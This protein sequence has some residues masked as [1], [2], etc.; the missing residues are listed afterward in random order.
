MLAMAIHVV[1]ADVRAD[2]SGIGDAD[3]AGDAG[4]SLVQAS[5]IVPGNHT[6]YL[7]PSVDTD[8]Y[9]AIG[10][11]AGE[12]ISLVLDVPS[13]L[14]YDLQLYDPTDVLVS[15]STN[16]AGLNES[17]VYSI[18]SDGIWKVRVHHVSGSGDGSY[19]LDII[20]MGGYDRLTL[21]VGSFGDD[22]ISQHLPGISISDGT[23]WSSPSGGGR[24]ASVNSSFL[25]NLYAQTYQENTRYQLSIAYVSVNDVNLSVLLGGVWV[26]VAALPGKASSW[27]HSFVLDSG[28]LQDSSSSLLGMNV[29]LRFEQTATVLSI[30]AVPVAYD[31]D[32]FGGSECY[33]GVMPVS[34]WTSDGMV[35]NGSSGATLRVTLP[36]ADG[37]FFLEFV[38]FGSWEGI[39]VQQHDGSNWVNVGSLRT[40]GSSAVLQLSSS[41]HDTLPSVPGVSLLIRLTS[42]SVNL[43]QVTLWTSLRNTDVGTNGDMDAGRAGISLPNNGLWS[44]AAVVDGR[45][46]RTTASSLAEFH[47]NGALSDSPYAVSI[48]YKTGSASVSVQQYLGPSAGYVSLGTLTGDGTWRTSTFYTSAAGMYDHAAGAP[49]NVLFRIN[50]PSGTVIVDNIAMCID[51][52][53]DGISDAMESIRVSMSGIGTYTYALNPFSADTDSDGLN[54]KEEMTSYGTNPTDPDTDNDGLLDGSEKYSYSWGIEGF[55]PI[56]NNGKLTFTISMPAISGPIESMNLLIGITHPD[57]SE[58][59]VEFGRIT[60]YKWLIIPVYTMKTVKDSGTGSGANYFASINLFTIASPYTASDFGTARTWY[61]YV[62]DTAAD[63]DTGRLDYVKLQVNGRTDPLNSDSDGDGISDGEEVNF[64]ADGWITNPRS[65]DSDGDGVSDYNEINGNTLCGHILDP[66]NPDTDDDGYN[67]NVDRYYGDAVIRLTV[68][69]YKSWE[70]INNGNT[71]NI[72]FVITYDGTSL[73]TRR[74]TAST[75]GMYYPGWIY[76]FDVPDTATSASMTLSAVADDAGWLGDD[77]KLDV[78]T[79]SPTEYSFT[80]SLSTSVTYYQTEGGRDWS[81]GDSDAYMRVSM[82]TRVAE[83]ARVIVVNGTGAD[84]DYGLET[85]STGSYRYSADDQLYMVN[86]NVSNQSTHFQQGANT[87]IV[88]RAIA[89]ACQMND[90]LANVSTLPSSNPFHGATFHSTQGGSGSSHVVAVIS[91]KVNGAVAETILYM[92]TQDSSDVRIGNNVTIAAEIVYLLHLPNDVV[93]SI[94][95]IIQNSGLGA[96]PN[97]LDPL[98]VIADIVDMVFNFLLYVYTTTM[99]YLQHLLDIGLQNLGSLVAASAAAV[100]AALDVIVDAFEAYVVWITEMM[101]SSL[102]AFFNPIIESIQNLVGSYL[103]NIIAIESVMIQE[104]QEYGYAMTDTIQLMADLILGELFRFLIDVAIGIDIMIISLLLMTGGAAFLL[105]ILVGILMGYIMNNVLSIAVNGSN[106]VVTCSN[107]A[108][109]FTFAVNGYTDPETNYTSQQEFTAFSTVFTLTAMILSCILICVDMAFIVGFALSIISLIL[110]YLA[111]EEDSFN[112]GVMGIACSISSVMITVADA[113]VKKR[114]DVTLI[115]A[116]SIIASGAA[117]YCSIQ[118]L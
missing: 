20:L 85:T 80:Y 44:S 22:D 57:Q 103:C 97:Y 112:L 49:L 1:M 28:E 41:Y 42:A 50:G 77:I 116:F 46:V 55:H 111:C 73:S 23:G 4:D 32:L 102:G 110:G 43:S 56:P 109:A 105:A 75:G 34:G 36:Y 94:P 21:Q 53:G 18:A 82:Q 6:G 39:G 108:S 66:T 24:T 96:A 26:R 31:S 13:V 64:G 10:L 90:S 65:A 45:T 37:T 83:K 25:L 47:L 2:S 78:A 81:D 54:D 61:I 95:T 35:V 68:T 30:Q 19:N 91:K 33:P 101:M 89:L 5:P 84:G 79:G 59:K 88:P 14:N 92:L 11:L 58:I 117:V 74:L 51:R 9:Y 93:S 3:L 27:T 118:A 17:I 48:T 115:A 76:E 106:E 7:D 69:Q 67:D 99:L 62:S 104:I 72:F 63:A 87:I 98:N 100:T 86:L 113:F 29:R 52:D 114:A 70:D 8:D 60:S 71:R 15:S 40:W 16:G 38:N 107:L 12:T